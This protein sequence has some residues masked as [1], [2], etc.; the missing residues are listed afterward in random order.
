MDRFLPLLLDSLTLTSIRLTDCTFRCLTVR[1]NHIGT[2]RSVM[3]YGFRA[4]HR[5]SYK[6]DR[7]PTPRYQSPSA[8]YESPT[9]RPEPPLK[10]DKTAEQ[11]PLQATLDERRRE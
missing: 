7:K 6:D 8:L 11:G 10:P 1:A 9:I 2:P 5:D 4:G 3:N